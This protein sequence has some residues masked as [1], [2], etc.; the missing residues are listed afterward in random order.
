MTARIGVS[1]SRALGE[2]ITLTCDV[3]GLSNLTSDTTIV[4]SGPRGAMGTGTSLP[5]PLNPALLSDAGQYTCMATVSSTL[6]TS[7]VEGTDTEDLRLQSECSHCS[8]FTAFES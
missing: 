8:I 6:L 7:D 3:T 2:D 1:G 4:F 5:L